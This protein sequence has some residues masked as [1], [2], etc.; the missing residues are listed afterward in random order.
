MLLIV[1]ERHMEETGGPGAVLDNGATPLNVTHSPFGGLCLSRASCPSRTD[2]PN[3]T[4]SHRCLTSPQL[5]Y[6]DTTLA[7]NTQV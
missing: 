3:R 5:Q 7:D 4:N 2:V 1:V 6:N